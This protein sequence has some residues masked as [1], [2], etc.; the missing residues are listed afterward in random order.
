MEMS[1]KGMG[2]RFTLWRAQI[3]GVAPRRQKSTPQTGLDHRRRIEG[4][5]AKC[6]IGR[7]EP[8]KMTT[9]RP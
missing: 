4:L 3:Q 2:A 5:F 8:S 6:V 1:L 7:S 9:A